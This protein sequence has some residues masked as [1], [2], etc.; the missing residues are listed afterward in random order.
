M[1][2]ISSIILIAT[3]IFTACSTGDDGSGNGGGNETDSFDRGAMLVNW[4]DNIIIPAFSDFKTSTQQLEELTLAFTQDPSEENL[5]ALRNEFENSYIEFQAVAMFDIG[6]A[7]EVG[8]RRF[9]NTYPLDAAAVEDKIS[10]GSY[11]LELPSSFDEQGFPAMDYLLNDLGENDSE[12][13][14]KYSSE[15]YSNYLVDVAQRINSLTSEVNASWQ[16]DYRDNFVSNTSSSSTGSVDKLTNKFVMYY[17]AFLRSGK[18]GFPSGVFTGS[19]SPI[20]V[21]AYYSKDLSKELYLEALESVTDF[22]NGNGSGDS[23]KQYLEFLDRG[24]LASDISSQLTAIEAQA[25][26]LDASLRRQV[27]TDNTKMLEAYDELQKGVVLFK[28]DMMQALSISIDY[29]DSDGD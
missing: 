25:S 20:N 21:E 26:N 9:L 29:V 4:A 27:E 1:K 19:P 22:Y 24:E 2:R 7:E 18:I 8:F 28:L 13:V 15:N 12:I 5:V 23:Y 3:L 14:T 17:E 11:N 10:S 6:K 16:G